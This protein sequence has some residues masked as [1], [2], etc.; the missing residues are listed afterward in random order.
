[1][2]LH[3]IKYTSQG[4]DFIV[5]DNRNHIFDPDRKDLISNLCKR[6]ISVGADGIILVGTDR[7]D[8]TAEFFNP[9]G[10]PALMCGNGSRAAVHFARQIEIIRNEGEFWVLG[11]MHKAMIN[12]DELI[13]VEIHLISPNIT[14]KIVSYREKNFTGFVCDTGVPHFVFMDLPFSRDEFR[15][16]ALFI[17]K[18]QEFSNDGINVNMVAL[19]NTG[20]MEITT[21]ERGVEDLTLSCGTGAVAAVWTGISE[22]IVSLPV[23]V[24]SAGGCIEVCKANDPNSLWIWGNV[25]QA[26]SGIVKNIE[27]LESLQELSLLR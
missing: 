26:Y 25:S 12:K 23:Q 18:L 9:D 24:R 27:K 5:I 8:F 20:K 11:K 2:D 21:F 13:G 16:F 1:M 6:R 14:K 17:R 10:L 15:E 3:F 4:N 22:E 7:P 19:K